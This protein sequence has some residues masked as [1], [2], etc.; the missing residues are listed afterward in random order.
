MI[1]MAPAAH[2]VLRCMCLLLTQSG[3]ELVPRILDSETIFL[4]AEQKSAR[5][6]DV[7]KDIV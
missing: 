1:P 7:S 6:V 4:S 5:V 3:H 2:A